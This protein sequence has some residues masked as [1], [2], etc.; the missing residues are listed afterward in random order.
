MPLAASRIYVLDDPGSAFMLDK[1]LALFSAR[2]V[3]N[4]EII[5]SKD[6]RKTPEKFNRASGTSVVLAGCVNSGRSLI[7]I[8]RL[9]REIEPDSAIV[10]ITG[11]L[12]AT[13]AA[14]ANLLKNNLRF[15]S[16]RR[17]PFLFQSIETIEV[18]DNTISRESV[19]S[20]EVT[21]L[22]KLIA[23]FVAHKKFPRVVTEYRIETLEES[24]A[25][26]RAGLYDN[27]FW[28]SRTGKKLTLRPNFFLFD[29]DYSA[30][31]ISQADVFFRL[32]LFYIT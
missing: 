19:W 27:L 5:S 26:E 14:M 3:P 9:L 12:R 29:F 2:G 15:A 23:K 25:E 13:S 28:P 17:I 20:D 24:L 4:P 1:V 7:E 8:S 22:R 16:G 18:P 32:L 10:F 30:R 31:P 6:V 11:V 21:L